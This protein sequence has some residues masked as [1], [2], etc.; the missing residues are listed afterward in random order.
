MS[1]TGAMRY[2]HRTAPATESL[3]LNAIYRVWFSKRPARTLLQR[4]LRDHAK[5]VLRFLADPTFFTVV[6]IYGIELIHPGWEGRSSRHIGK[7]G[8]SD[9]RWIVGIKLA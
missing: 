6:D 4:L 5:E 1:F 2:L 9:G 3:W 8:Q 7:T